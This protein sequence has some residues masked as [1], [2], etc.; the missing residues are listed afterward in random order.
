MQMG[1]FKLP[2]ILIVAGVCV[3]V[4]VR[5]CVSVCLCVI[6]RDAKFYLHRLRKIKIN[7]KI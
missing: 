6:G 2:Q 4:C 3:W 1:S 7:A 5:V